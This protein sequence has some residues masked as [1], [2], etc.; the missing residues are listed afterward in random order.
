MTARRFC[1][2]LAGVLVGTSVAGSF[3][4]DDKTAGRWS[5]HR[6]FKGS[7]GETIHY[8]LFTPRGVDSAKTYPLVVWLHGGLTSNALP[9]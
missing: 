8:Y 2:I 7:S 3:G 5:P 4:A 6:P 9:A 1:V